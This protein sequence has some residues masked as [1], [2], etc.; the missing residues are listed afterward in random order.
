[1]RNCFITKSGVIERGSVNSTAATKLFFE[2]SPSSSEATPLGDKWTK[3]LADSIKN[4]DE[5]FPI[6]KGIRDEDYVYFYTKFIECVRMLNFV[7]CED[8]AMTKGNCTH[9]RDV[10]R[11]SCNA[12]NYGML[13][14]LLYEESFYRKN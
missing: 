12:S 3:I 14:E 5:S 1:M 9:M 4:C 6:K 10:M 2:C 11:K 7:N 8:D 13:H